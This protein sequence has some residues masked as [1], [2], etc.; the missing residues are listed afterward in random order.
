VTATNGG[1]T[2]AVGDQVV[3]TWPTIR[4]FAA[5]D[6]VTE[7]VTVTAPSVPGSIANVAVVVASDSPPG[8]RG[9]LAARVGGNWLVRILSSVPLWLYSILLAV[10]LFSLHDLL[11]SDLSDRRE[12]AKERANRQ[13]V[14]LQ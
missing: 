13:P 7:T 4:T 12:A 3:V 11:S 8:G 2:S 5:G 10:G 1:R 14:A 6:T 9:S